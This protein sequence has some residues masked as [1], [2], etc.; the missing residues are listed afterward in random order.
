MVVLQEHA[1]AETPSAFGKVGHTRDAH[2]NPCIIAIA[3][4]SATN[5]KPT[6]RSMSPADASSTATPR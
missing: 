4:K 3:D 6:M 1:I 2:T 5:D